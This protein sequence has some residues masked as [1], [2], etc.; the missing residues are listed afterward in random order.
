M[1]TPKVKASEKEASFGKATFPSTEAEVAAPQERQFI[2]SAPDPGSL[3]DYLAGLTIG[4]G[5]RLDD[6]VM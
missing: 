6:R 3:A 5:V 1:D 2:L 4:I